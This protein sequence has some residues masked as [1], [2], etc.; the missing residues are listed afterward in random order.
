MQNLPQWLVWAGLSAVFAALTALFAKIGV[1][2]VDS[3]LAMALRTLVVAAVIVPMVV[4]TG[5][6]SNPLLLAGRT[7]LFLVLSALAT[8]ASWLFY[9]RALQGGELAKVAVVDKFS[10]VLVI[11]LAYLLLDERPSLREWSGI[12][13]VLAGV[14]VLATKK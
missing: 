12:G 4:M 1:K 2:G 3:D 7:Q 11:V 5:K 14:I 10:V 13:L 9:F 8:G 6:W